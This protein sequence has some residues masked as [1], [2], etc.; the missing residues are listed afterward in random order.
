[1]RLLSSAAPNGGPQYEVVKQLGV[2]TSLIV[3]LRSFKLR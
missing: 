2:S 3:S 1:M